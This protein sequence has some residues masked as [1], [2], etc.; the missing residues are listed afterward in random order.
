MDIK[1]RQAQLEILNIFSK[2]SKTFALTG[3][4]ALE[5]YYLKH[6]FSRDLDF[7]STE[8]DK[9]EIKLLVSYFSKLTGNKIKLENEFTMSNRARVQ[10]YTMQVPGSKYSLKIDFIEDV[11]FEKPNIIKFNGI[12]VYDIKLIY[13]QKITTV[14]GMRFAM[15]ETGREII[16]GRKEARDVVDLYFL[17]KKVSPLHLFLRTLPS[18]FQRGM[19]LWYRSFSRQ[20]FKIDFLDLEVYDKSLDGS[21]IVVYLENEI[22]KFISGVLK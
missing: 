7:F 13:F 17:S 22:K 10:F 9:K 3:G 12:P 11:L 15:N 6:Q 5:L 18:E 2:Y 14:T 21:K 1:I 8:Y 4:T 19:I 20:E 16:T